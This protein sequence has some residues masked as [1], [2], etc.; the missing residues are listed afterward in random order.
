MSKELIIALL[1]INCANSIKLECRDK[2][3]TEA[4]CY[5]TTCMLNQ[6]KDNAKDI[7]TKGCTIYEKES[8]Q[9]IIKSM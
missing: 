8:I 7:Q 1:P 6:N 4:K 2:T 5:S 9:K 3:S